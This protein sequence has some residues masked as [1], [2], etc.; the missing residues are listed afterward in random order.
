[1]TRRREARRIWLV[2]VSRYETEVHTSEAWDDKVSF[3]S[4]RAAL[5]FS[6]RAKKM[7]ELDYVS[8]PFPGPLWQSGLAA[9]AQLVDD[10]G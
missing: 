3:S 2:N 8:D 6:S 10:I 1:M 5:A 9:W 7:D 4:Q